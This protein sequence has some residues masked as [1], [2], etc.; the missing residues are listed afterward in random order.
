MSSEPP[1]CL[2]SLGQLCVSLC[3]VGQ[4]EVRVGGGGGRASRSVLFLA[5][6]LCGPQPSKPPLRAAPQST[7]HFGTSQPSSRTHAAPGECLQS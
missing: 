6:S 2:Q 1:T 4:G 5:A 3:G 7:L